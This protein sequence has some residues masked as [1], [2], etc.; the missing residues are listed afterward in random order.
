MWSA[1]FDTEAIASIALCISSSRL[2][3]GGCTGSGLPP[4]DLRICRRGSRGVPRSSARRG[5]C[6]SGSCSNGSCNCSG[7]GTRP[8]GRVATTATST[9]T[10]DTI[11]PT[12]GEAAILEEIGRASNHPCQREETQREAAENVENGRL[13]QV[14]APS[15]RQRRC[16]GGVEGHVLPPHVGLRPRR[17]APRHEARPGGRE[18]HVVGRRAPGCAGPA[19]DG[20]AGAPLEVA[21]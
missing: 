2:V 4:A 3:V 10:S 18:E 6:G 5:R 11:G 19:A 1:S 9:T 14:C 15:Y 20:G 17:P 13:C 16:K 8:V 7:T 21:L 12:I